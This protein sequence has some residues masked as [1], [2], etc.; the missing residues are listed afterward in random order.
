M[1]GASH[2][3]ESGINAQENGRRNLEPNLKY[4][5]DITHNPIPIT[6]ALDSFDSLHSF[7][8]LSLSLP[9]FLLS[10]TNLFFAHPKEEKF[11]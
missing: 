8:R 10:S 9:P 3:A 6:M 7:S 5:D 4:N 2:A 11:P 1:V